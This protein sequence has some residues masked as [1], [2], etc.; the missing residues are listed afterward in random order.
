[1]LATFLSSL[2][3]AFSV[4]TISSGEKAHSEP[5]ERNRFSRFFQTKQIKK[6]KVGIEK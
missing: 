2:L 6:L 5:F 1:M 3:Q 4:L